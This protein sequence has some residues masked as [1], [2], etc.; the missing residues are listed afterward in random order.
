VR[1]D[2]ESKNPKRPRRSFWI[3]YTAIFYGPQWNFWNPVAKLSAVSAF[4]LAKEPLDKQQP[5]SQARNKEHS[6]DIQES[7]PLDN[8]SVKNSS[9]YQE[10]RLRTASPPLGMEVGHQRLLGVLRS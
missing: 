5:A 1:L 7:L 2:E 10:A 9:N 8:L 3:L 6:R 4:Y